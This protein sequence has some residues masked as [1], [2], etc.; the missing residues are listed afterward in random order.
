M[1]NSPNRGVNYFLYYNKGKYPLITI[2]AWQVSFSPPPTQHQTTPFNPP[3]PDIYV[4]HSPP[5]LP[6]MEDMDEEQADA[7]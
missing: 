6:N 3:K 4:T 2:Y 5:K 7:V 1:H